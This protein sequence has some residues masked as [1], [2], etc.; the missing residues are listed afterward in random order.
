MT[1]YPADIS[2]DGEIKDF[3]T[4]FYVLSDTPNTSQEYATNFTNDARA[5]FG[6]VTCEGNDGER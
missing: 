6:L 5:V 2:V 3:I 4:Q 1:K